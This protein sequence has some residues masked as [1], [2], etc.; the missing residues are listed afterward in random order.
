MRRGAASNGYRVSMER[1]P[2]GQ[3]ADGGRSL[4]PTPQLLVGLIV[5]AVGV[6]FTLDNLGIVRW[7]RYVVRYWPAG[8]IAIGVLK[9]WQ[10]SDGMGRGCGGLLFLLAGTWLLLEQTALVRISFVD[11]WPLVLVFFGVYLVWHGVAA[12]GPRHPTDANATVH[13][14]PSSAASHAA[15][16]RARSRGAA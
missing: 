6:L 11:V 14:M 10:A 13:A 7:D 9:L 2:G 3:P 12:P 16:T 5:I 4:R 15:A 8:L 1:M